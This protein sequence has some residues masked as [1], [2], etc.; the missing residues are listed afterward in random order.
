MTFIV[1]ASKGDDEMTTFRL[2]PDAAIAKGR[3]LVK[4]GWQVC[5]TDPEGTRY[6]PYEFDRLALFRHP[7][8]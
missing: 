3:T 7:A 6:R 8:D 1:H 2:N 4:D 5:I